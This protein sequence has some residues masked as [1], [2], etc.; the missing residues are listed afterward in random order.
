MSVFLIN[1]TRRM[2][3]FTLAHKWY[4]LALGACACTVAPGK[5][6]HRIAGS[7]TIPSGGKTESLPDAVLEV[8][9]IKTAV[10]SG[11]L[12]VHRVRSRRSRRVAAGKSKPTKSSKRSKK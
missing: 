7:L 2:K 8:P 11:A 9:D 4:C 6:G 12:T 1:N 3:V 5:G 10:T